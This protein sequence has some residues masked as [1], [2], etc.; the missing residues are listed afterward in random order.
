MFV[1]LLTEN[2]FL[3]CEKEV[4]FYSL[5]LGKLKK[6]NKKWGK[7]FLESWYSWITVFEQN[8]SSTYWEGLMLPLKRNLRFSVMIHK[9]K[10]TTDEPP[11]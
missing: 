11:H 7:I 3:F 4:Y 5:V 1:W 8:S 2:I 6:Q 10:L 9:H